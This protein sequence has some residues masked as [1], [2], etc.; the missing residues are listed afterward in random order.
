M[1]LTSGQQLKKQTGG[2]H[3]YARSNHHTRDFDQVKILLSCLTRS[4]WYKC[5]MIV[6]GKSMK[7]WTQWGY[8]CV[9][10][11]IAVQLAGGRRQLLN[12][13]ISSFADKKLFR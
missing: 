9:C 11:P 2:W 4:M 3:L 12:A 7:H 8:F 6:N 1:L 13:Q 5:L 10:Y